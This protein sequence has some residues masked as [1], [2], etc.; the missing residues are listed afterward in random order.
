[1]KAV[2]SCKTCRR[3]ACG[4]AGRKRDKVAGESE[5]RASECSIG[6]KA[7]PGKPNPP[8]HKVREAAHLEGFTPPSDIDLAKAAKQDA[9]LKR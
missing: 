9:Y 6:Y 7:G 5:K 3:G 4:Y 8:G 1:M 2:I